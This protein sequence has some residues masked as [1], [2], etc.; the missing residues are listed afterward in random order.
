MSVL[1]TLTAGGMGFDSYIT[2]GVY[3]MM[4]ENEKNGWF[5]KPEKG[6]DIG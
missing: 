5:Y 4:V 2:F 3:G 6:L 1:L